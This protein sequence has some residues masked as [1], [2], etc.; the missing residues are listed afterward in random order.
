M[1][2][3]SARHNFLPIWLSSAL[4]LAGIAG[5]TGCDQPRSDGE[6]LDGKPHGV[7]HYWYAN[8]QREKTG[9][10]T[11]SGVSGTRMASA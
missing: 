3:C 11:A 1:S 2:A 4:L 10:N 7:W 8:G 5:L 6:M 9:S